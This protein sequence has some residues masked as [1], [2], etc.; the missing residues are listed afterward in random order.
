MLSKHPENCK[1]PHG[2]S[3]RIE[4]VLEAP[5]LD[6]NDMVCDFKIVKVLIKEFLDAWDHA[7][8][9]NTEDP[10]FEIL[11]GI[12]GDRILPFNNQDPTTEVMAQQLFHE[13]QRRMKEYA[14]KSNQNYILR[15]EVKLQRVR[16]GETSSS[17]AEY[18]E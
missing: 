16:L 18:E 10:K 2:H 6:E 9:V 12:Y 15:S 11:R 14:S 8:A 13:L 1:Y 3:R 5:T 17:W 4:I 7:M